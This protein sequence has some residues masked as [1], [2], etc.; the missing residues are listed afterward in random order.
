MT[1]TPRWT[2]LSGLAGLAGNA[3]L[4]LFFALSRPWA[5][6]TTGYE[7]LGPVNDALVVVQFAAMV[8]VALAVHARLGLGRGTTAAGVTAMAGV[9]VLQLA[10]LGDLLAFEV[11]VPAVVACLVVVFGW[12]LVASRAGRA[13]LPPRV[14]RLG[15]AV[16][17][18][19]LAGLVVAAAGLLAAPDSVARYVAWGLGGVAGLVGY[20]GLPLWPLALVD[21]VPALGVAR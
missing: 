5:G 8:P 18:A 6:V 1:D 2:V 9:V 21:R 20:L 4:I 7:W 19:F 13:T 14:V 15:T 17:V 11:Q 10:L 12:V 16:G 3:F